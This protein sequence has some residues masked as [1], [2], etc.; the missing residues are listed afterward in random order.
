MPAYLLT[1]PA[2]KTKMRP[3]AES[4]EKDCMPGPPETAG[5]APLF[6]ISCT[7]MS[8]DEVAEFLSEAADSYLTEPVLNQTGSKVRGMSR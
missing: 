6:T 2:G 5:D 7:G 3:T 4:E 1:A 8:A